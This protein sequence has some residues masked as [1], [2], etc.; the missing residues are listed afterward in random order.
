LTTSGL[1]FKFKRAEGKA[2]SRIQPL[3]RQ[4]VPQLE[5][6]FSKTEARMGFL[7]NS[8]LIMAYKP[9]LLEAF[10]QLSQ[11]I[12]D[13]ANKTSQQ[14][15]TLVGLVASRSAGCQ[16]CMAHTGESAHKAN[17]EDQK[18]AAITDFESSPL[19]DPVERATLRFAQR[20]AAV[21]NAVTDEDFAELRT[22]Y[23]NEEIVEI[24]AVIAFYGL[25]NRWNDSLATE[26]EM[27][28]LSFAQCTLSASGWSSGKHTPQATSTKSASQ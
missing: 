7:P 14:I 5:P 27:S 25:L 15:R 4:S 6:F 11:A 10:S 9:K 1:R 23:S 3:D 16:Y 2:M 22:Y 26:L 12:H 17:V 8:Q 13:P 19:F 18:I 21:P 24:M 28:P 20:A